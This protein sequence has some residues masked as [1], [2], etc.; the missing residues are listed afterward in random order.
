MKLLA[1]FLKAFNVVSS[2]ILCNQA[3]HNGVT[4]SMMIHIDKAIDLGG[5]AFFVHACSLSPG[6]EVSP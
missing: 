4:L 3:S 5:A 2:I 1:M 6:Q